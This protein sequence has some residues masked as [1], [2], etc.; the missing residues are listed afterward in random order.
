M[1]VWLSDTALSSANRVRMHFG[2]A[3]CGSRY[4]NVVQLSILHRRR[5]DTG[6]VSV[7]RPPARLPEPM[8]A[9][10][11]DEKTDGLDETTYA[12]RVA[13]SS[14]RAA[15]SA[16]SCRRRPRPVSR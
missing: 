6:R 9:E 2:F 3:V 7:S 8:R 5:D 14:S 13:S 4:E 16:A 12:A 10:K 15:C 1:N 11:N